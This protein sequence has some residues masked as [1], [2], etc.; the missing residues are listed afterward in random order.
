MSYNLLIKSITIFFGD[1]SNSFNKKYGS[2]L[3]RVK[4]LNCLLQK[5]KSLIRQRTWE[6]LRAQPSANINKQCM[7]NSWV[8]CN[9]WKW[10]NTLKYIYW[11]VQWFI[12]GTLYLVTPPFLGSVTVIG[13]L[14]RVNLLK[15]P[16]LRGLGWT[17]VP[18]GRE[19][20]THFS[21]MELLC[22]LCYSS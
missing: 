5:K 3:D 12:L 11:V 13:I 10:H 18:F 16:S 15:G 17:R 2:I 7:L 21:A 14:K 1:M 6:K 9:S 22:L 4:Y 19:C 20:H 8:E